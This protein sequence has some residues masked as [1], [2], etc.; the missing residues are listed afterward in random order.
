MLA[1]VTEETCHSLPEI[2]AEEDALEVYDL[3][4]CVGLSLS[5]TSLVKQRSFFASPFSFFQLFLK[6]LLSSFV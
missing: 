1:F 4:E 5:V 3:C 6:F 2:N